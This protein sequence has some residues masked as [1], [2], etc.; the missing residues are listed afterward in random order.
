M[1][2]FCEKDQSSKFSHIR[3]VSNC[4]KRKNQ[5]WD[6]D[7]NS[8][9]KLHQT[10]LTPEAKTALVN[11]LI[12]KDKIKTEQILALRRKLYLALKT[13]IVLKKQ[14]SQDTQEEEKEVLDLFKAQ[15]DEPEQ[16]IVFK[17]P[18]P[19]RSEEGKK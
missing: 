9:L 11:N 7:E 17:I 13:M 6:P 3:H 5:G 1:C 19:E 18:K 4:K 15:T 10:D 16:K 2:P 8:F 14:L 12:K